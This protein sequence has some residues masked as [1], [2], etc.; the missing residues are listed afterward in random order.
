MAIVTSVSFGQKAK[1]ASSKSTKPAEQ[2]VV[3]IKSNG[4]Q[5]TGLFVSGDTESITI[6]VSE[7]KIKMSLSEI[8]RIQIGSNLQ[9]KST[10][11][12]KTSL[13]FEAGLIYK[14]GGNQPVSRTTFHLLDKSAEQ[15]LSETGASKEMKDFSYL[16]NYALG[17][18]L[19]ESDLHIKGSSAIKSHIVHTST[20]DFDGKGVFENVESGNYWLYCIAGTRKGRVIWNLPIKIKDGENKV[21]LDQHNAVSAF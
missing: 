1:S 7:A 9:P 6:E 18:I 13:K 20:T 21:L 14:V 17:L 15:I 10:M 8:E 16:A 3:V 19:R 5:L 11:E 4:D 2:K 12:S